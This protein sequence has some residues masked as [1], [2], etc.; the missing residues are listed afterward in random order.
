MGQCGNRGDIFVTSGHHDAV[1]AV[2]CRQR[3]VE[4]LLQFDTVGIMANHYFKA[5]FKKS[6]L[7]LMKLHLIFPVYYLTV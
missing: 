1:Y 6:Y 3:E 7:I 2:I 5:D 4:M